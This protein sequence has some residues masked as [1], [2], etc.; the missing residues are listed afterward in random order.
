MSFIVIN[1]EEKNMIKHLEKNEKLEEFTKEGKVV[2]DFFA[3]WCGPCQMLGP[4]LEEVA[5]ETDIGIIKIDIDE[6]ESLAREFGVMSVPTLLFYE[7]GELISR[8]VGFMP[9]ESIVE[10]FK[11]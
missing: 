1:K 10:I 3:T 5:E 9:K 11:K 8:K 6:Q 4:V 2:V 7:Q